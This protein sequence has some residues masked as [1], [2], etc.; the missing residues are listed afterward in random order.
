[1][2][3]KNGIFVCEAEEMKKVKFQGII[4]PEVNITFESLKVK[5]AYY[6]DKQQYVVKG[7]FSEEIPEGSGIDIVKKSIYAKIKRKGLCGGQIPEILI[8]EKVFKFLEG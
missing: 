1:M 8:S 4:I 5:E 7:L 2:R 6:N 3:R